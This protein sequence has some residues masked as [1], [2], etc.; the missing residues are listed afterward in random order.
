[1]KRPL[2]ILEDVPIIVGDF[3]VPMDFGT[4]DMAEDAHT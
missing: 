1:M 2:G 4:L 3:Y